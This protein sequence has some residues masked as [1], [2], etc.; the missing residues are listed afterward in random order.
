MCPQL[1]RGNSVVGRDGAT[2]GELKQSEAAPALPPSS[3]GFAAG[4]AAAAG[5]AE[6]EAHNSKILSNVSNRSQQRQ[7]TV[8][9]TVFVPALVRTA[10]T[11]SVSP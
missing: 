10:S 2:A 5:S 4:G 3:E 6:W 8:G 7:P 11:M 1:K 9:A